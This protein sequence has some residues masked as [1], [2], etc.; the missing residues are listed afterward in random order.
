MSRNPARAFDDLTDAETFSIPKIED[1]ASRTVHFRE[2][3]QREQMC[4]GKIG[5]MDVIPDAG[6]VRRAVIG[7]ENGYV[8]TLAA[9]DLQDQRQKVGF[10]RVHLTKLFSCARS[11]EVPQAG[12]GESVDAVKPA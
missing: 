10:W 7:A 11:V 3:M 4:A 5:N 1:Q 6:P 9:S 2:R 12:V 8:I